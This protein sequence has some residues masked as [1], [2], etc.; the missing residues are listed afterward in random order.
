MAASILVVEDETLVGLELKETLEGM[1]YRVPEV[2][3]SGDEVLGATL[4][5]RP[6]LVLMDIHLKSYIDGIDAV[7][8]LRM[9]S[10]VP[11][12]YM[13]AYPAKSVEDRA[14]GTSPAD[15]L[16]KPIDDARLRQAVERALGQAAGVAG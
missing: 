2:I 7:T 3:A 14:F 10:S 12:V 8:R 1:G 9:V 15:Y 16:Q 13:T 11:V 5:H 4:R 6:D